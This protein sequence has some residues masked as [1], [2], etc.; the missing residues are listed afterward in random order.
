MNDYTKID[1]IKMTNEFFYALRQMECRLL[2]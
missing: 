1:N 2:T